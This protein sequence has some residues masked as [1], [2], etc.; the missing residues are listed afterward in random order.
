M[1]E[2]GDCNVEDILFI[3]SSCMFSDV[4]TASQI[5]GLVDCYP[6]VWDTPKPLWTLYCFNLRP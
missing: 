3:A 4:D 1:A 2:E 5:L 6:P